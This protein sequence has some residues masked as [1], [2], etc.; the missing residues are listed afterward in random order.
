MEFTTLNFDGVFR[1]TNASNDDFETQ[2]NSKKYLFP[3]KSTVPLIIPGETLEG[4]QEIRKVFARRYAQREFYKTKQFKDLKKLGGDIPP[5]YDESVLQSWIDQ[6]LEDL[7]VG[8]VMIGEIKKNN[9]KVFK[10]SKA[11]G[12]NDDLNMEFKDAPIKSVGKM[13]SE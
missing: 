6:C 13:P 9:E 2:W 3:A 12:D 1:F 10:G 7:P 4:I 8:K 5:T 11:V